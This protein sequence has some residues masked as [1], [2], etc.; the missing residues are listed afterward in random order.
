VNRAEVAQRLW[1]DARADAHLLGRL[2]AA[3]RGHGEVVDALWWRANPLTHTPDCRPDPASELAPL[4]ERV[5][6][7]PVDSDARGGPEPLVEFVDPISMHVVTAT[8]SGRTLRTLTLRLGEDAKAL[9]ELLERFDTREAGARPE[10]GALPDAAGLPD[11][12]E[13]FRQWEQSAA[14]TGAVADCA[15]ADSAVAE[16]AVAD[17]EMATKAGS[18]SFTFAP[19]VERPEAAARRANP[20]H[21]IAAGAALGVLGFPR[22]G[23]LCTP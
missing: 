2:R 20:F 4:V 19:E 15:V 14:A 22:P 8:E 10:A 11:A 23:Y 18:E 17:G 21:L 13:W 6:S 1:T 9:D 7:R 5:Y 12:A 16:G 3:Y